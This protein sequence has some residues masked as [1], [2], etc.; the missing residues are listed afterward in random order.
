MSVYPVTPGYVPHSPTSREAAERI[1]PVA[2]TMRAK[3][4]DVIRGRGAEGATDDEI[5]RVLDLSQ[6][7]ARPR[8]RELELG[9]LVRDSGRTRPTRSGR[10]AA[11]WVEGD[12]RAVSRG[13]PDTRRVGCEACG[14]TGYR[15]EPRHPVAK[16]QMRLPW[17]EE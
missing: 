9:G 12:G 11:V 16:G 7:S 15:L 6:N 14:G 5:Q 1:E 3:V 8:R 17:S 4:L 13:V 2:G 10:Q